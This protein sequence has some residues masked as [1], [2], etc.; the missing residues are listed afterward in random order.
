MAFGEGQERLAYQ[1]FEIADDRT[2][3]LG[4][5]LVAKGSRFVEESIVDGITSDGGRAWEVK[6]K[7]VRRFC[8]VQH[9][10]RSA[11]R[12]FND[13]MNEIPA[14]DPETARVSFLDCSVYYL[15]N[16]NDEESAVIVER[17]LEGKFRK[18]NSNNG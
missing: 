1:F 18:W 15:T 12:A 6:D 5:P 2:T 13:K 14:L 17:K 10:A 16:E 7:F 8:A 9:L 4:A 3:V 11:A